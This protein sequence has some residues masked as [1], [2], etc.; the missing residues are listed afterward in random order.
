MPTCERALASLVALQVVVVALSCRIAPAVQSGVAQRHLSPVREASQAAKEVVRGGGGAKWRRG[1]TCERTLASLVALQVVVVT[2]NCRIA[3]AV[4]SGVAQC[5]LNTHTH[6]HTQCKESFSGGW[7]RTATREMCQLARA[8]AG[9]VAT[10]GAVV[11][12]G[13]RVALPS[14]VV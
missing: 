8:L 6:T 1:P 12:L 13:C 3:S 14:K 5:C 11:A 7:R 10:Q 2:L 4:Q 9:L